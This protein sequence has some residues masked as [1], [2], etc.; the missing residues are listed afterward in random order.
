MGHTYPA[1]FARASHPVFAGSAIG[2]AM[3]LSSIEGAER[4]DYKIA[5]LT[6]TIA[7]PVEETIYY[8]DLR[9]LLA[10]ILFSLASALDLLLIRRN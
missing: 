4:H 2:D 3:D 5:A 10:L 8:H 6:Q 7:Y 9:F 1:M